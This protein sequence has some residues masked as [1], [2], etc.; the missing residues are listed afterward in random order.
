MLGIHLERSRNAPLTVWI[1]STID[2]ADHSFLSLIS[3]LA[4]CI[5]NIFVLCNRL[6]SMQGLSRGRGS[7]N[8]LCRL[9]I[10][11]VDATGQPTSRIHDGF[12]YAGNLRV[13]E[14]EMPQPLVIPFMSWSHLAHLMFPVYGTQ[15]LDLLLQAKCMK[16]LEINDMGITITHARNGTVREAYSS[17]LT[18]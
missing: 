16:S 18:D 15:D 1:R 5:E 9:K 2:V 17:L 6:C 12:D 13:F 11:S 10:K 8:R 14:G 4:S 3:T 7:L